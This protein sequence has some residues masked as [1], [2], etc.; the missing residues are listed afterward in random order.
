[1]KS[2][3]EG[4]SSKVRKLEI[5]AKREVLDLFSGMYASAFKGRGIEMEDVREFQTGDDIRA[6]SWTKT[7]QLGRPFVKE[8]REERDL[9]VMLVVDVSSSIAFGSQY[10]T[11]RERL[12]E[13]G[14]LIAFSAI[15]N[16]DRVGLILFSDGIQKEIQPRRGMRHGAR[17]IR[18]LLGFIPQSKKTDLVKTLDSFNMG[19]KKRCICFLLSDFIA[20]GYE[21]QFGFT[22][23]HDD[24][25][26]IRLF[27]P[28]EVSMPKLG[29]T[30]L[31]DLESGALFFVDVND[32]VIKKVQENAEKRRKEF[33]KLGAKYRAG[34]LSIE[35]KGSFME[36]IAAYFKMRKERGR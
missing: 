21:K 30:T 36:Q 22:A 32:H 4:L 31:Q 14:A 6:I 29:L 26:A 8:F 9:T 20:S 1:M 35:T 27:D 34:T 7:A 15:Y 5:T 10:E 23:K 11:K 19:V 28:A 13:I 33:S 18:E 17:I 25:V 3:V 2:D 16:H 12:A 24:L